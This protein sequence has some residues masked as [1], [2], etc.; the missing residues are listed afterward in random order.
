MHVPLFEMDVKVPVQFV[1][2][3]IR[4]LKLQFALPPTHSQ[5]EHPRVSSNTVGSAVSR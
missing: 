2:A 3:K 5:G 1:V 4:V